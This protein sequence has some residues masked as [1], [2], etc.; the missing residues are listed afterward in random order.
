MNVAFDEETCTMNL[1]GEYQFLDYGQDLY[2]PQST[3]D[4]EGRRTVI[5]WM[6]MPEAV[7]GKWNG[8][9]CIPRVVEEEEGNIY[10]TR[11]NVGNINKRITGKSRLFMRRHH[12][13]IR[14]S[15]VR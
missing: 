10:L 5:A 1:S 12:E 2:A 7:D 13:D 14:C 3:L 4:E 11:M 6:R 8:M 15:G 9:F